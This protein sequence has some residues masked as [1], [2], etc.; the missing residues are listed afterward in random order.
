M[1]LVQIADVVVPE[2]F[3]PYMMVL[4]QEKSRLIQS[5]AA[6]VNGDLNTSL[7]GGGKT[8]NDPS[9]NDIPNDVDN[10]GDDVPANVAV[11]NKITSNQEIQV[12][13]SRNQHWSAADLSAALAGSD[14][15]QAIAQ[16]VA[17]YWTRRSQ[18]A[19]VATMNGVFADNTA[20]D[21]GDYTNDITGVF[22]AGVTDFS[23]EAVIDTALTAGDTLD[24]FTMLMVHSVVYAKMRKNNL[25]DFI[26][27]SEN[28]SQIARFGDLEVIVDDGLPVSANDYDSWLFGPGAIQL[29]IGTPKVPTE[30]TREALQGSGAGVEILSSRLEWVLHPAGHAYIGTAPD[31]GPSNAATAN[32]LAAATSWNR[33]YPER[34][35][36]Q[37]ARLRTTE[38]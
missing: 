14:P 17:N 10:V 27:D 30:V 38:A 18:A 11:P 7:A 5:G 8:F 16:R 3:T 25:I 6:I 22:A 36:I 29:G 37:I 21:A 12:R 34:K 26:R 28:G 9:W 31:G 33:V 4:T 15:M 2:I 20:N 1:A 23:A 35:Q 19:F 24:S 13:L 32:N